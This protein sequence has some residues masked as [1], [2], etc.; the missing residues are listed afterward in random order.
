MPEGKAKRAPRKM[1]QT[2]YDENTG[3]AIAKRTMKATTRLETG[4]TLYRETDYKP[5]SSRKSTGISAGKANKGGRRMSGS[6][7]MGKARGGT[8]STSSSCSGGGASGKGSK[9]CGP[10]SKK[11]Q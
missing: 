11:K 6:S 2:V 7:G 3:R 10:D 8:W 4:R 5:I 1:V 9:S